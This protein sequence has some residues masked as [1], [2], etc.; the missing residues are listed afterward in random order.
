MGF[1]FTVS[2]L[3]ALRKTIQKLSINTKGNFCTLHVVQNSK[4]YYVEPWIQDTIKPKVM[5][6]GW[7]PSTSI[8]IQKYR[9]LAILIAKESPAFV[10]S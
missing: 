2:G 7:R 8:R 9:I 4:F 5:R 10:A 1:F 3:M 6:E